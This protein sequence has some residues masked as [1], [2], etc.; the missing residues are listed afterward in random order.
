MEH[1]WFAKR[2]WRKV[3]ENGDVSQILKLISDGVDLKG[4]YDGFTVLHWAVLKN[5]VEIAKILLDSQINDVNCYSSDNESDTPLHL[6]CLECDL[7]MVKFLLERGANVDAVNRSGQ[8]P[9][10]YA[11]MRRCLK[12]VSV[13]VECGCDVN[14]IDES[15]YTPLRWAVDV[16]SIDVV[17]EL[18]KSKTIDANLND[19]KSENTV[20]HLATLNGSQKMAKYLIK[21]KVKLDALNEDNETPLQVAMKRNYT[22]IAE[23]IKLA[24]FK[25][26]R[27]MFDREYL[28]KTKK[29][30][31]EVEDPLYKID[32]VISVGSGV[33]RK[34]IDSGKY[35]GLCILVGVV[36]PEEFMKKYP[37]YTNEP[38]FIRG[39]GTKF[40]H[41][42][43]YTRNLQHIKKKL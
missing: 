18:F 16:N 8:T 14:V 4:Y 43:R 24:V 6:A 21:K 22:A 20:L 23:L 15:G 7:D 41:D 19:E 35:G 32:G 2:E 11:V 34:W 33:N 27:K 37:K 5:N 3:I 30:K 10:F 26:K 42:I 9:I 17:R 1:S 38:Y 36:D 29:V 13:L 12:I 39:K 28:D 40:V 25:K 31:A